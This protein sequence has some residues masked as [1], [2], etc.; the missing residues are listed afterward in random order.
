MNEK[1]PA[2]LRK[3]LWTSLAVSIVMSVLAAKWEQCLVSQMA[4]SKHIDIN[5]NTE[6]CF[7]VGTEPSIDFSVRLDL[8]VPIIACYT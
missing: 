7:A 6:S 4:Y 3:H 5:S 2:A 1:T 8:I